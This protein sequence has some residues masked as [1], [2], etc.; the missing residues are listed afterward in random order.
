[1]NLVAWLI[2]CYFALDRL[3]TVAMI[4]R[5]IEVTRAGAV[6]SLITGTL[7]VLGVVG[8]AGGCP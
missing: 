6:A 8:L 7:I 4:G 2:V 3:A 1:M 5:S